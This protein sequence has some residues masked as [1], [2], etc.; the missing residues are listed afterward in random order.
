[1]QLCQHWDQTQTKNKRLLP[2]VCPASCG[3]SSCKAIMYKQSS[4]TESILA[5][6]LYRA[7]LQSILVFTLY[8]THPFIPWPLSCEMDPLQWMWLKPT[9]PPLLW[10][11]RPPCWT[12]VKASMQALHADHSVGNGS[13]CLTEFRS[14]QTY[15]SFS[16]PVS[17]SQLA[18]C[19]SCYLACATKACELHLWHY[20]YNIHIYA[21]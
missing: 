15:S 14:R 4:S 10:T 21:W 16:R 1:M 18:R 13:S 11:L 6:T 2:T 3:T 17:T 19:S 8:L 9:P 20:M 12:A 7:A 5:F